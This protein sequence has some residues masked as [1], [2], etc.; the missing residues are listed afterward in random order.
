MTKRYVVGRVTPERIPF[1]HS[2]VRFELG[3]EYDG[4]VAD[5][6]VAD[7]Q[8]S[9]VLSGP[10]A[11]LTPFSTEHIVRR[12][13][14]TFIDAHAFVHGVHLGIDI[15]QY[16]EGGNIRY[17][18]KRHDVIVDRVKNVSVEDIELL[19]RLSDSGWLRRVLTDLRIGLNEIT[20]MPFYGYRAIEC[21]RHHL[22]ELAG[23][24]GDDQA[25]RIK[26]WN[27]L[28]QIL[29]VERS[30]IDKVERFGTPIRHGK[31]PT[32]SGAEWREIVLI[33][34]DIVERY[35]LFLKVQQKIQE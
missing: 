11:K 33:V 25:T 24:V 35:I 5:V 2:P 16:F 9:A 12:T 15:V 19:C 13:M 8:L 21:V 28:R 34:W 32:Y 22:S 1:S 27:H 30:V 10:E 17:Q 26:Q 7:N 14:E 29:G 20:D 18:D 31:V 6:A 3:G 23:L 4:V